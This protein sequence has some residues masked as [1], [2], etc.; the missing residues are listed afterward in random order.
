MSCDSFLDMKCAVASPPSLAFSFR[1]PAACAP[2]IPRR[3]LSSAYRSYAYHRMPME[4]R[5]SPPT[6]TSPASTEKANRPPTPWTTDFV[7]PTTEVVSASLS[8]VHRYVA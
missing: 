5:V 3:R 2:P 4:F 7:R 8:R 1:S 6:F